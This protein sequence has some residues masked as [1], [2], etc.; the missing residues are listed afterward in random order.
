MQPRHKRLKRAGRLQAANIGCLSIY[1][2]NIVRGYARHFGVNLLC[3]VFKLQML[4]YEISSTYIE[5]LK[6]N[7]IQ[8]QKLAEKKDL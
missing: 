4:G 7:E 6:A 8:R 1:G 3:S 5:Q 2:K